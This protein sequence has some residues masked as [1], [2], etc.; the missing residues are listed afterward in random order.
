ME[1]SPQSTNNAFAFYKGLEEYRQ[2]AV[3]VS[4]WIE[5]YKWVLGFVCPILL[6]RRWLHDQENVAFF[7]KNLWGCVPEEWKEPLLSLEERELQQMVAGVIRV[8]CMFSF[9]WAMCKDEWPDSLKEFLSEYKRLQLPRKHRQARDIGTNSS[10]FVW[11]EF[12]CRS[13]YYSPDECQKSPR[14]IILLSQFRIYS[15]SLIWQVSQMVFAR[16][17][18]HR[19]W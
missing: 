14:G 5:K 2:H 13:R 9:G 6:F 3:A 12:S 10:F 4:K 15:R 18:E 1:A 16:R 11:D 19:L 17:L 7:W 8:I